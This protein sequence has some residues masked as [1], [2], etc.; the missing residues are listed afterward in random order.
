[1]TWR[2][3]AAAGPTVCDSGGG[4]V[5]YRLASGDGDDVAA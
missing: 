2:F 5:P 4:T 3:P 1:M